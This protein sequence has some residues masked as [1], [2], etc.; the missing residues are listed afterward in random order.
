LS[1]SSQAIWEPASGSGPEALLVSLFKVEM[2]Y[3]GWRCGG[4]KIL[5]LLDGFSCKV[6]LQHLSKILL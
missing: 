1:T 4:V 3:T 6:Y 5:P 2:F